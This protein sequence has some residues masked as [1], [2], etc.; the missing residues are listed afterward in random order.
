MVKY[1]DQVIKFGNKYLCYNSFKADYFWGPKHLS[2]KFLLNDSKI[3]QLLK[4]YPGSRVV[5]IRG[6]EGEAMITEETLND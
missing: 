4:N 6:I 1:V 3:N 5:F 2:E